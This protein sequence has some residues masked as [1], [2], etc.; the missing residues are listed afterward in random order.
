MTWK[1]RLAKEL[2]WFAVIF[3]GSLLF[4]Y[5]LS[6]IVDQHIIAKVFLYNREK[7]AFITTIGI[8]YFIRMI[9]KL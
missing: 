3:S 5:V 7:H 1:K 8:I 4:W 2:Y 6:H 9:A